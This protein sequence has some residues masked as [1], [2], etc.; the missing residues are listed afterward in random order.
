MQRGS[1]FQVISLDWGIL[2]SVGVFA[3]FALGSEQ[4]KHHI[5]QVGGP[6]LIGSVDTQGLLEAAKRNPAYRNPYGLSLNP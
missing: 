2:D 1:T 6:E 5:G 3:G 4:G